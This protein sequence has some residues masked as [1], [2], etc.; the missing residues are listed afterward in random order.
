M[1]FILSG[2]DSEQHK[3]SSFP[4]ALKLHPMH[5]IVGQ[6]ERCDLEQLSQSMLTR[7]KITRVQIP[8]PDPRPQNQNFTLPS[9][10]R[11][12]MQSENCY[13]DDTTPYL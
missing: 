10:L 8:G 7:I 5:Q 2:L 4:F 3:I 13:F 6:A 1:F 9:S 12:T 11:G